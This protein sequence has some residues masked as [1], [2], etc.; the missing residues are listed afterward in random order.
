MSA[1]M[2]VRKSLGSVAIGMTPCV[3]LSACAEPVRGPEAWL[4]FMGGNVRK[5]ILGGKKRA[6]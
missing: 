5:A 4:E 3:A 1:K 6:F 2:K